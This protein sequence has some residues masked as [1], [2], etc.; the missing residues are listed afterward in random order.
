MLRYML[1]LRCPDI[2]MLSGMNCQY[3]FFVCRIRY[4]LKEFLCRTQVPPHENFLAK[5]PTT[6]LKVRNYRMSLVHLT[7]I[8]CTAVRLVVLGIG[9]LTSM[10]A[11]QNR[12]WRN[13]FLFTRNRSNFTSCAFISKLWTAIHCT[14]HQSN[15]A[16]RAPANSVTG[17]RNS[18]WTAIRRSYDHES[19]TGP[20]KFQVLQYGHSDRFWSRF[21]V[22]SWS[23][24]AR[25]RLNS[26]SIQGRMVGWPH[27]A[28][29]PYD[30]IFLTGTKTIS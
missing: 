28:V 18:H 8:N 12:P 19:T 27:G 29:Q 1:P 24:W 13:D 30:K 21:R 23:I 2:G 9:L 10:L 6:Y 17:I 11:E 7:R 22:D 3:I 15:T 4:R 14:L 26:G 5:V 16:S 20:F 25:F